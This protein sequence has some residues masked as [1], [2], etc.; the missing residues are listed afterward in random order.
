MTAKEKRALR[1]LLRLVK[2]HVD[3][4][5]RIATTAPEHD[6]RTHANNELSEWLAALERW[7][8]K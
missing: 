3:D 7:E 5:H 4:L 8:G 1:P 2:R 6:A